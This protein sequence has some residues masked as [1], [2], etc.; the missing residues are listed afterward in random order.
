MDRDS[1]IFAIAGPSWAAGFLTGALATALYIFVS[2]RSNPTLVAL[3]QHEAFH[4]KE[5]EELESQFHVSPLKLK[6]LFT[7]FTKEMEKG[8]TEE[9]STMKMIPTY[10]DVVP[11][12]TEVG[13]YLAL[14]L[15]GTNFRV[16]RVILDG[17]G[18]FRTEQKK[19]LVKDQYK[20]GSG[21]ELFNFL[22]T[23]VEEFL[24]E[25]NMDKTLS[26]SMGFTFSFPVKQTSINSGFLLEWTKGFS[27]SGVP[28]ADV[29]QMLNAAFDR[30]NV[31]IRVC[32]LV[33]DTV[34]T[35][36][37][38]CY[39]DPQCYAGVIFGTGTNA[40]YIE[41]TSEIPKWKGE[42]KTGKMVI[43]MEWGSFDDTKQMLPLTPYD[44]QLDRESPNPSK[45]LYEKM[46]SGMYLG[47]LTR[48][49]CL[50]LIRKGKLFKRKSSN[51]FETP[52]AFDTA[53]MSRIE[54][55]H[56]RDLLDTTTV[57]EE[58]M[59]IPQTR[60]EDRQIVKR[61]C[62]LIGVRAAR[63]SAVGIAGVVYKTGKL[64]GCDI[65][66]DG[67]VFQQYPHFQNRMRDAL[68]EIFGL[69]AD[70]IAFNL[71]QDGSGVGAALIAAVIS[72]HYSD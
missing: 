63:L 34:G 20:T 19:F 7:H 43:N 17:Q 58:I 13:S 16:V 15:G 3:K 22:A 62:E 6:Q 26:Y 70:N 23:C 54:R 48:L 67:S 12:G 49:V 35:L 21:E 18:L 66:V 38:R 25:F 33:N 4:F 5:L 56:S 60:L 61:I 29:V 27:A 28:G 37:A 50:S 39:K 42:N 11:D 57:L 31:K 8:L 24:T 52:H 41:K 1:N 47:E 46:I 69:Q 36:A 68:T 72:K 55:D 40:C 51:K 32:A 10:L 71:T 53:Y 30:K 9:G 44:V 64:S 2:R 14:D 59:G 45:Q 65:G